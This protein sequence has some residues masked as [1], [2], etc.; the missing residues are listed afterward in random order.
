M[1]SNEKLYNVVIGNVQTGQINGQKA[2]MDYSINLTEMLPLK[3][4]D[5]LYFSILIF[6]FAQHPV[7]HL[8]QNP[9][10]ILSSLSLKHRH[11]FLL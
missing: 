4:N 6:C 10:C 8:L 2:A 11:E 1:N 3:S 7:L 5:N 9:E